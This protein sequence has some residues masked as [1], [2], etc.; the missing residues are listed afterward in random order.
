MKTDQAILHFNNLTLGYDHHPAVHHLEYSINT[1]TLLAVVGPNGSGKSTL[2]KGIVGNLK[3]LEGE[4]KFNNI[5]LSEIS[6]LPQQVNIDLS[7][8]ISVFDM[9]S[10]GL[11]NKVGSFKNI[12]TA[13]NVKVHDALHKVGL[14]GFESRPINALSGGQVQRCLFARLLLQDSQLILLDEPFAAIDSSTINDL[15]KL[16]NSWHKEGRTII[17]VLHD[18]DLVKK[19][20]PEALLLA[21]ESI[22]IGKTSE[23]L[24]KRNLDKANKLTKSFK[25][26][27]VICCTK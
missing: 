20:F 5:E 10:M 6:Y 16:I 26:R 2:L 9:V 13:L 19:H 25:D 1:G 23:V 3:P 7:F 15:M 17:A 8:P 21:R 11:W 12:N 27:R 18:F 4:I 24:T 14:C 22:A